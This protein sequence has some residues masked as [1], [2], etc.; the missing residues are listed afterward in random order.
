MSAVGTL[1]PVDVA[2]RQIAIAPTGVIRGAYHFVSHG[3]SN[4]V[5]E[6]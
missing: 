1:E 6:L 5:P 2:M 4:G 3:P